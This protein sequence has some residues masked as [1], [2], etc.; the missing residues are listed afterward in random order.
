[1]LKKKIKLYYKIFVRLLFLFLYGKVLLPVN[2]N[3]VKKIKINNPS[4]RKFN[5]K[6]YKIYIIDNGRIYTDNN[7]NVAIIKNNAILPNVSFQQVYGRLRSFKHNCVLLKGTPSFLKK[8]NGKVFNLCQGASGN[9]YFHFLFDIIPKIYLLNSKINLN[10]IDYFYISEPKEWQIKILK[11]LGINREKLLSSRKYNHIIA[12]KIYVV[13]HPWYES[14]YIH[15][16]VQN[17]PR[18]IILKNR[19]V[20]LNKTNKSFTKKK[21]FLDRSK[22]AFNHCQ[23]NNL[24]SFI[25]FINKKNFKSLR[26]EFISFKNQVNLFNNASIVI[27]AHG[28]SLTNIIFCKPKTKIIEIIPEDLPNKKCE[29]ISKILNLKYYRIKTKSDNSDPNYPFKININKKNLF[30]INK[31]INL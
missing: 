11:T 12:N 15:N 23:I 4:F 13:D 18:W 3:H 20:F 22:S 29:R 8:I 5:N 19:E 7:E 14:G 2:N 28:A 21:I 17:I 30:L 10:T 1:M 16:N 27:G 26:P 31:I 25:R 9:N 24:K 6:K